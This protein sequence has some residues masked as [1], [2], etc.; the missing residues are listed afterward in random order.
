MSST[1]TFHSH[2]IILKIY[3]ALYVNSFLSYLPPFMPFSHFCPCK[4]PAGSGGARGPRVLF[5]IS[6]IDQN[7]KIGRRSQ[8]FD[9]LMFVSFSLLFYN[10]QFFCARL[11]SVRK[12]MWWS[13]PLLLPKN[14]FQAPHLRLH[15]SWYTQENFYTENNQLG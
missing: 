10:H 9:A 6:C 7:K 1:S 2:L 8:T 4:S 13:S 14:H 5:N 15:I 11:Y 12:Y 3:F